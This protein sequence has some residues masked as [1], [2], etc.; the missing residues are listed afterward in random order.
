MLVAINIGTN[1]TKALYAAPTAS[2]W[3][4]L[5]KTLEVTALGEGLG[6]QQLLSLKAM[7]R[8]V[9]AV[10]KM[11]AKATEPASVWLTGTEALRKAENRA[12]FQAR[13]QMLD[14]NLEVLSG[15]EEAA[16]SFLGLT[17]GLSLKGPGLAFDLGAGS[18]EL[19][20]GSGG[21][22]IEALSLPQG[23]GV[24]TERFLK[25]DPPLPR[26]LAALQKEL[27]ETFNSL[28][29]E[30]NGW[31]VGVGG[32]VTALLQARKGIW[33]Y[34]SSLHGQ[35]LTV[36]DTSELFAELS[37]CS[38]SQRTAMAGFQHLKRAQLA[39]AGALVV[40]ELLKATG[41]N[42]FVVSD[43]GILEGMVW[44]LMAELNGD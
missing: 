16:L 21:E 18:L 3:R 23:A 7:E 41:Q 8:T 33:E 26:E 15:E 31:L 39:P 42:E 25:S 28:A 4:A 35:K 13:L 43:C 36:S 27:A 5:A 24:L 9:T 22:L 38:A 20:T 12:E 14:L 17:S 32:T 19:M 6:Q 2:G 1:S 11:V 40:L 29:L 10:E 30:Q 34:S 44:K 37:G